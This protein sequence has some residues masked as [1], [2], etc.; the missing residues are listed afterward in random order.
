[1][2][3]S[4]WTRSKHQPCWSVYKGCVCARLLSLHD[5]AALFLFSFF[6]FCVRP[7]CRAF[8]C[9][10]SQSCHL[11]TCVYIYRVFTKKLLSRS[12]FTLTLLHLQTAAVFIDLSSIQPF[13]G[14]GWLCF[15]FSSTDPMCRANTRIR[16]SC[17]HALCIFYL[18]AIQLHGG[19]KLLDTSCTFI[20]IWTWKDVAT[21]QAVSCIVGN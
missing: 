10:P 14:Y 3:A 15:F 11:F 1:M 12:C 13:K 16:W 8:T 18:C 9:Y 20:G 7:C 21:Y 17:W 4:S 19:S 2:C 5:A 6:C